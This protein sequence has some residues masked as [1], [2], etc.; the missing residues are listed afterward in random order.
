MANTCARGA[1]G[2]DGKNF[3]ADGLGNARQPIATLGLQ[4]ALGL[5]FGVHHAPTNAPNSLVAQ[6]ES[7]AQ[8]LAVSIAAGHHKLDYIAACVGKS[9]GYLSRLQRGKREIPDRLI[10]PLCSAT[11]SRLLRQWVDLQCALNG[12]DDTERLA[13]LLRGAA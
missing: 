7:A 3:C 4:G 5:A 11:G 2:G 8:A 13:R 10:D 12:I 6:C 1:F 9:R